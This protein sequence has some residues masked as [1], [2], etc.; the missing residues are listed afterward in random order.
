[1]GS[2]HLPSKNKQVDTEI[3]SGLSRVYLDRMGHMLG[4]SLYMHIMEDLKYYYTYQRCQ[5][6]VILQDTSMEVGLDFQ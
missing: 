2:V 1:M 3:R 6:N 5:S 4:N